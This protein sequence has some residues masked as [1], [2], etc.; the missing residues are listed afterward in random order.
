MAAAYTGATLTSYGVDFVDEHDARSVLFGLF[1][2]VSHTRGAHTYEHF[3][4]VGTG[5]GEERHSRLSCCRLGNVGFTCSRRTHKKD[6]L[7]NSGSQLVVFFR[8]LKEIHDFLKLLL[9]LF[10]SCHI[11]EGDLLVAALYHLGS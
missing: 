11:I 6:S 5:Y 9:F 3:H 8:V 7:W 4:E 10:K 1:K 2:E